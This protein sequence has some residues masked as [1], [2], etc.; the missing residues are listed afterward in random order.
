VRAV[1]HARG[2]A[3]LVLPWRVVQR[4]PPAVAHAPPEPPAD[5]RERSAREEVRLVRWWS[6][7]VPRGE[8][9]AVARALRRAAFEEHVAPW[10][11]AAAVRRHARKAVWASYAPQAEVSDAQM[12]QMERA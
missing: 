1:A 10:L 5:E 4:G 8:L 3:A 7:L 11:A 2:Q 6:E 9:G 12:Q